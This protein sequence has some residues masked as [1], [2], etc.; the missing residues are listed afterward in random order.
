MSSQVSGFVKFSPDQL[1]V[2]PSRMD[3]RIQLRL[4]LCDIHD[5]HYQKQYCVLSTTPEYSFEQR[6]KAFYLDHVEV[7]KGKRI[8]RDT[9]LRELFE[10][11]WQMKAI[12]IPYQGNSR[13]EENRVLNTIKEALQNGV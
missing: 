8:D 1:R 13:R 11:R 9:E 3:E 5:F 6:R 2:S 7:H 12:G 4:H 10:K